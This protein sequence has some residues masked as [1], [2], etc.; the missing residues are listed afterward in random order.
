MT[1]LLLALLHAIIGVGALAAGPA[2]A[3]K[4]SGEGLTFDTEW[5]RGSPFRDYRVPGLFLALVIAPLHLG[6]ALALVR[7]ST[8]A[9]SVSMVAGAVLMPWSL[10]Q[11]IA[12][13]VRHWTQ[14]AWY[15]L[16]TLTFGL[17]LSQWR[18]HRNEG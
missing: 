5:L 4:P 3:W 13:G 15:T 6:A 12:I 16:F 1:R 18:G 14:P 8:I 9:P 17:A 7:R 2:L 10:V 11:V